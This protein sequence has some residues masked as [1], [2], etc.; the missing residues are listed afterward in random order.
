VR[1]ETPMGLVYATPALPSQVPEAVERQDRP[2]DVIVVLRSSPSASGVVQQWPLLLFRHNCLAQVS[3]QLE[4]LKASRVMRRCA[5]NGPFGTS[6]RTP[7][8]P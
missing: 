3:C 7:S 4:P 1:S 6:D 2:L 5:S 8:A